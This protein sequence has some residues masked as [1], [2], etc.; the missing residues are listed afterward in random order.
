MENIYWIITLIV[1]IAS[2]IEI[3]FF[4]DGVQIFSAFATGWLLSIP[5]MKAKGYL[6]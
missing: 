2:A 6:R 1:A 5:I 4:I 3:I